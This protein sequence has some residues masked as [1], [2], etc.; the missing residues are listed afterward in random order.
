MGKI[1][2]YIKRGIKYIRTEYRQPI[3][4]AEIVQKEKSD[5]FK[6]KVYLVTG[7]GSG[8]GFSIAKMLISENAKVIITGRNEEKLINSKK[9]LGENCEYYVLDMN[10]IDKFSVIINEIYNKYGKLDGLINNAG[11]SLHEWDFLKV[12]PEGFD[13]QF[14]T[15]LKGAYFLTQEY[16]KMLLEKEDAGNVIFISSER[17]SMAE[18]IPYGLTKAAIDSFTKGLSY[19]YYN[20]GIRINSIAP[21]VTATAMT[22]INKNEDLFTTNTSGR[23][24]LPEE[25]AEIVCYLLS[26]YSKCISG[27]VIHCN[28]GNHIKMGW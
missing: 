2:T 10:M 17:G 28:G 24:F 9:E 1:L 27:E 18:V 22:N 26:D 5:M 25:I 6:D 12:T 13:T 19:K 3:I 14:Y 16:I 15:N 20:K 11:V 21:G 8:I 7:G 4:K 23:I